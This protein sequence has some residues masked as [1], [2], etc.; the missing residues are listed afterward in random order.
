LFLI[1]LDLHCAL[2]IFNPLSRL[3]DTKGHS[4]SGFAL[5]LGA[6]GTARAAAFVASRKLGLH[7]IYYNRTP[8]KARKSNKRTPLYR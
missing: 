3:I 4:E 6:G 8:S 7:C 2:G 5:I 1:Y